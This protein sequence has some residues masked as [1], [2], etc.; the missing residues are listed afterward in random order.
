ML[1]QRKQHRRSIN[2]PWGASVFHDFANIVHPRTVHVVLV[3]VCLTSECARIRS[4]LFATGEVQI[5]V[6]HSCA[7]VDHADHII[8]RVLMGHHAKRPSGTRRSKRSLGSLDRE[9]SG[10]SQI[11]LF[12]S[13]TKK[14][15]GESRSLVMLLS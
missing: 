7:G 14:Q 4:A 3:H 10:P 13:E 9:L 1:H 11:D 8:R 6:G 5:V 12:V 2:Q 15:W